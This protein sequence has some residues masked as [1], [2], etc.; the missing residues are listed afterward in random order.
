MP[1]SLDGKDTRRVRRSRAGAAEPMQAHCRDGHRRASPV[2]S[3]A[4]SRGRRVGARLA[5]TACHLLTLRVSRIPEQDMYG[6]PDELVHLGRRGIHHPRRP[7]RRVLDDE[8]GS[9]AS[10]L[11]TPPMGAAA[12]SE[13]AC[14]GLPSARR[15]RSVNSTNSRKR[16][17][18]PGGASPSITAA[19]RH[20]A[21]RSRGRGPPRQAPRVP[22]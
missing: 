6:P 19:R 13:R 10:R 18:R 12:T 8:S 9:V 14:S 5:V 1:W 16:N 4:L 7:S 2:S 3:E 15:E 17:T 11:R 22:A 20:D 21:A